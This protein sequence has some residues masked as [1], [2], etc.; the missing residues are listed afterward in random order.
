LAEILSA[1]K[2][3]VAR[4]SGDAARTIPDPLF[5]RFPLDE[6]RGI[7]PQAMFVAAGRPPLS[8]LAVDC[9]SG[10]NCDTGALDPAAVPAD[11]TVTFAY[12]KWGQLQHPGAGACGRLAVADIGV[13]SELDNLLPVELVDRERVAAL[14]PPRPAD[15][16]KGT[17]GKALVAGG[18]SLYTGAPALSGL[19]AARSG[20]GLVQPDMAAPAERGR[21]AQP[22]RGHRAARASRP[23]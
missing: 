18:S 8:V 16:N 14:L 11:L 10:L 5:P 12:P 4:R 6:A 17:F 9:P 23:V 7:E 20:A 22:R 21:Q 19:A 3:E 1:V 15:A 13:P 2:D